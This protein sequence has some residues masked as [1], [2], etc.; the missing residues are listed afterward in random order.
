MNPNLE[1]SLIIYWILVCTIAGTLI[2]YTNIELYKTFKQVYS[3]KIEREDRQILCY[4]LIFF[5]VYLFMAVSNICRL[6]NDLFDTNE[7]SLTAYFL[8]DFFSI[9]Y[10]ACVHHM[11]YS[12]SI[13]KEADQMNQYEESEKSS[14]KL[15]DLYLRQS[16]ERAFKLIPSTESNSVSGFAED[17]SFNL[18]TEKLKQS[19]ISDTPNSLDDY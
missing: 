18:K 8:E 15:S 6:A 12:R 13:Q 16:R 2:A 1:Q 5:I 7:F 14:V 3:G 17:L 19:I 9:G 11:N 10:L 4:L